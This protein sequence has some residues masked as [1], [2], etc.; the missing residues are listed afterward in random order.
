M[1]ARRRLK[2]N[3]ERLRLSAER[4]EQPQTARP[5]KKSYV[6]ADGSVCRAK[7]STVFTEAGV[8]KLK[9]PAEGQVDF[10]EKIER[11]L[12]LMLRLSY[13]GT[14]AWRVVYYV[15]G[16]ARAKTL[17]HYPALGVAEARKRAKNFDPQRAS[18]S[19]EAG[20][21]REVAEDWL[22][23]HVAK[24]GLRSQREIERQLHT[25]IYPEWSRTDF[26]DIRRLGVNALLDHIEDAHG[27]PQADAV[28]ATIRNIMNWYATRDEKYSTPIVKGMK[29]DK[30][31]AEARKRRRTLDDAEICA[32]WRAADDA[33][34]FG[35]I[36][37]FA[38]LT[39]QRREKVATMRWD[40]IVDDDWVIRTEVDEKGETREKGNGGKLKLLGAALDIIEAQPEVEGNPYVFAGS[41]RGRRRKSLA[42]K[43]EPPTF[44]SWSKRKAQLDAKL[45]RGMPHWTIHDLRRTA[46]TLLARAGVRSEVA[47]HL[48]GHAI[49]GMEGVYNRYEY[50]KEKAVALSELDVL[51]NEIVN[52]PPPDRKVVPLRG[53][54]RRP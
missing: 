51:L 14:R 35:A 37:K 13:G 15:N 19:A 50:Y 53:V 23:R 31:K 36:V 38:L 22:K 40:D 46:R 52:P 20:S 4:P 32:V 43:E 54:A 8:K 26:F 9:L 25:Y 3:I 33:G 7:R 5:E 49:P 12:T 10:F 48:L 39:G 6:A 34:T 17:G 11:G 1:A 21:F 18:A 28:L 30:R 41:P 29:R 47:E 27:A 24:Q 2:R 45:P 44:N 42:N 16:R